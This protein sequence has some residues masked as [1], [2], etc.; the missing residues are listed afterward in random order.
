MPLRILDSVS[1]SQFCLNSD[2]ATGI[3]ALK[4][5]CQAFMTD[6]QSFLIKA[7]LEEIQD[8]WAP[9]FVEFRLLASGRSGKRVLIN[10]SLVLRV[11]AFGA[12]A[13]EILTRRQEYRVTGSIEET[14]QRFNGVS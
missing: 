5:G 3:K 9:D 1:G 14:V 2:Y 6:D 8:A 13:V 4:Q 7:T 12:D 11:E 10:P